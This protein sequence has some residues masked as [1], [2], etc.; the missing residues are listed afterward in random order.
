MDRQAAIELLH[1]YTRSEALRAHALSVEAA[2]RALARHHN[3]DETLWGLTGLLHDFDYEIHPTLEAHPVQGAPILREHGYPE[4]MITAILGHGNHTGV[5]RETLLA[6]ALF[7]VDELAGFITAV[8]LVRPSRRVAD[9]TPKSVKKKFKDKA[10]ARAVN[11]E[12]IRQGI[13]E[14]GVDMDEHI[15]RVVDAMASIANQIGLAGSPDG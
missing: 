12:D 10:F 14:L 7:S 2:M 8:A 9:V 5:A 11:R 4:A 3:E 6:R 15:Q 1:H 13:E